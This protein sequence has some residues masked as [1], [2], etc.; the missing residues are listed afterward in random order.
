MLAALRH[1]VAL[2]QAAGTVDLVSG[3]RL[4][5]GVGVGGAFNDTLRQEWWN[6]GVDPATRASRFEEVVHLSKRLTAGETITHQGRHFTLDEVSVKPTSPQN[7]GVP[8]LVACHWRANLDRQFYRA[9]SLGDGYVSISD[10][11][12]EY[13]QVR[14]RVRNHAEAL[15]NDFSGMEAVFYVTVNLVEDEESAAEEADR[16]LRMYYGV[17]IWGDRWGPYG[18]PE[19]AV[20]RIRRYVQAGAGTVIV[21]FA[22]FDQPTQMRTFL[23]EVVPGVYAA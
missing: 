19:R 22:S 10:Y 3:G 13:V 1:P 20:D 9:A 23:E 15:G 2:A 14:E 4:V 12:E 7:G 6:A 16:F 17:N 21:R 5:L 18:P 8:M 11:P